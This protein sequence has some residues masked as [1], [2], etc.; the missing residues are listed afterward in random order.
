MTKKQL[1]LL[2]F[3]DSFIKE[4]QYSP[5]YNEMKEHMG[6]KSKNSIHQTIYILQEMGYV[7]L[8]KYKSD[9]WVYVTS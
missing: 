4:N 5:S 9:S 1:K 8:Y 7:K 3:I 2:R 6:L